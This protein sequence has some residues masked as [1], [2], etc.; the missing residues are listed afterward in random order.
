M[1]LDGSSEG[2]IPVEVKAEQLPKAFEQ[3]LDNLESAKESLSAEDKATVEKFAENV[4]TWVDAVRSSFHGYEQYMKQNNGEPMSEDTY[5]SENAYKVLDRY[6]IPS[7]TVYQNDPQT[8]RDGMKARSG[9]RIDLQPGLNPEEEATYFSEQ[10]HRVEQSQA[11]VAPLSKSGLEAVLTAIGGMRKGEGLNDFLD[12]SM[13][14]TQSSENQAF[15]QSYSRRNEV[16]PAGVT[17]S[18]RDIPGLELAL[19]TKNPSAEPGTAAGY[20]FMI[21]Q[22]KPDPTDSSARELFRSIVRG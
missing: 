19:R 5:F 3:M 9:V 8:D 18:I 16:M 13:R 2:F 11:A 7:L 15:V 22:V 20:E 1:S 12:R 17:L 10:K 4:P 21:L 14:S 6:R